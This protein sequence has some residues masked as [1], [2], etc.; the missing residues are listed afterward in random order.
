MGSLFLPNR[1]S[2]Q[3]DGST[4]ALGNQTLPGSADV[5][6]AM[7]A[8]LPASIECW[9][10]V[11]SA[12]AALAWLVGD[13]GIGKSHIDIRSDRKVIWRVGGNAGITSLIPTW[14]IDL[15]RW[16]WTAMLTAGDGWLTALLDDRPPIHKRL[17]TLGTATASMRVLGAVFSGSWINFFPGAINR[18]RFSR[19][20]RTIE[21]L[22]DR[23][24]EAF[25]SETPCVGQYLMGEGSGT[26]VADSSAAGV[27]LS[28][29]SLLTPATGDPAWISAV[30][31]SGTEAED[32]ARDLVSERRVTIFMGGSEP[33]EGFALSGSGN[34]FQIAATGTIQEGAEQ[35]IG[36]LVGARAGSTDL[37][38]APT[39]TDCE[40]TDESCFH[41]GATLSVR[42][43]GNANPEEEPGGIWA[44]WRYSVGSIGGSVGDYQFPA[45]LGSD[46]TLETDR[47]LSVQDGLPTSGETLGL[48][49][50]N[51]PPK[52]STVPILNVAMASRRFSGSSFWARVGRGRDWTNYA[53]FM[54]GRFA[55]EPARQRGQVSL[56]M[57]PAEP[58][59]NLRACAGSYTS[60]EYPGLPTESAG[61]LKQIRIGRCR[62]I[63]PVLIDSAIGR[64]KYSAADPALGGTLRSVFNS[65]GGLRLE[66][67]AAHLQVSG[68]EFTI[69]SSYTLP[70][71]EVRCDFDGGLRLP[72]E[73]ALALLRLR[74]AVESDLDA[75]SYAALD[76]DFPVEVALSIEDETTLGTAIRLLLRSVLASQA[77][78]NSGRLSALGYQSAMA[79]LGSSQLYADF[80]LGEFDRR[81][82]LDLARSP[83]LDADAMESFE[84]IE[85]TRPFS[86][87]RIAYGAARNSGIA[88]EEL[89]ESPRIAAETRSTEERPWACAI[90]GRSH[91]RW[92]GSVVLEAFGRGVERHEFS[93]AGIASHRAIPGSMAAVDSRANSWDGLPMRFEQVRRTY[94]GAAGLGSSGILTA[95]RNLSE[96]AG[97]YGTAAGPADWATATEAEREY[98]RFFSDADGRPDP[99][100]PKRHSRLGF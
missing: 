23:R 51:P 33:M 69:L 4:D 95:H 28:F 70:L 48:K 61:Q 20:L 71:G 62:G 57:L 84:A 11:D 26:L 79:I 37:R 66:I 63:V 8:N 90:V 10:R 87:V 93:E 49:L 42:L 88:V 56:S 35:I 3:F 5:A 82:D 25:D 47:A 50:L 24:M 13:F 38:L 34:S 31:H 54:R 81:D 17:G 74:G 53:T 39:L 52:G 12:P 46:F 86:R 60:E 73:S 92:L 85:S 18:V 45:R 29:G 89:I 98:L 96:S 43:A 1:F 58:L 67:P 16:Y 80:G 36:E 68:P 7:A 19:S 22:L 100:A 55:G 15:S 72:G 41:D 30:P 40:A 99:S 75:A 59:L 21:D 78:D 76:A 2:L 94:G 32:Y 6:A 65:I 91:A 44:E 77:V 83:R 14:Q 27:D 64:G 9:F 97:V